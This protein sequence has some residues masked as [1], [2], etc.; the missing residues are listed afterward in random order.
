MDR[1][2]ARQARVAG[3]RY[4]RFHVLAPARLVQDGVCGFEAVRRRGHATDGRQLS[5]GAA[6]VFFNPCDIFKLC[7]SRGDFTVDSD[8]DAVN[9]TLTKMLKAKVDASAGIIASTRLTGS[10]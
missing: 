8:R 3:G 7:A 5:D 6:G 4:L 10:F 9:E 2:P 1:G